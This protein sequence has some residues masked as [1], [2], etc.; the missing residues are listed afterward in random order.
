MTVDGSS[1]YVAQVLERLRELA[2]LEAQ[3][4]FSEAQLYP[5]EPLYALSER[6]SRLPPSAHC[7]PFTAHCSPLTATFPVSPLAQVSLAILR[8][9]RAMEEAL[10]N[11]EEDQ[12]R[13]LWPLVREQLPSCL[14]E[15]HAA[16]LP[17]RLPWEY[18]SAMISSGFASRLVYREGLSFCEALPDHRLPT[19]AL[20]Y[21]QQEQIVKGLARQVADGGAAYAEQVESLLLRGGVRA[22]T[23]ANG[24]MTR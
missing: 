24:L 13:R 16:R 1:R 3:L 23:E 6:V 21:L 19:F 20:R 7:A 12:R 14:F 11:M 15:H 22:A 4:L 8:A 9:S 18:Q 2:G 17:Q 5:A 10:A